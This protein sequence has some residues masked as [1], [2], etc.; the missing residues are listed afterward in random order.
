MVTVALRSSSVIKDLDLPC[1]TNGSS[2]PRS[3]MEACSG[4]RYLSRLF[5][6]GAGIICRNQAAAM[7]RE[8]RAAKRPPQPQ[9]ACAMTRHQENWCGRAERYLPVPNSPVSARTLMASRIEWLS[10]NA[11]WSPR[12]W[13]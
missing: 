11:W 6:R 8:A 3:S 7:M 4:G 12:G 13:I 1:R 10:R 2:L 5:V 9:L